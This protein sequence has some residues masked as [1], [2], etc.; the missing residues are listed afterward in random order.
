MKRRMIYSTELER[1]LYSKKLGALC[2]TA[3][4]QS[5]A[6][7]VV[8]LQFHCFKIFFHQES[9]KFKANGTMEYSIKT[10]CYRSGR[11]HQSFLLHFI[12]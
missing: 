7:A 6:I 1:N 3:N 4:G 11:S 2:V 10:Q 12:Q 9:V 8:F 5:G